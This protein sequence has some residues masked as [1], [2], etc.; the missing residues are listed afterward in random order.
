M[1]VNTIMS[2]SQSM[3]GQGGVQNFQMQSLLQ[4]K[5]QMDPNNG[6]FNAE[7]VMPGAQGNTQAQANMLNA[8][9]MRQMA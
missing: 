2:R 7:G 3:N 4:M 8:H 6:E 9:M 5:N 1:Q